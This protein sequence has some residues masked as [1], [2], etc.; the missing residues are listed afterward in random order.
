MPREATT[1]KVWT[2]GCNSLIHPTE[3]SPREYAWGEN[4]VNRGGIVQNRPG[5]KVRASIP[6]SKIQG[7]CIFTPRNSTARLVA[8]VDGNIYQA[9][10][11]DYNFTKIDGLS[12]SATAEFVVMVP[13]VKSVK[14]NPDGS[15]T[16]I[17]PTPVLMIQ[18]G[19]NRCGYWDGSTTKHLNPE[20][21]D[22][23]TPIGLWMAWTSSRLWVMNGR[24][25]YASDIADPLTF[26]EN[27]YL[28]ER[29]NFD[30]PDEGMGL[31]ETADQTGLLAFTSKTTTAFKSYI[32]DR[33]QWGQTPDFQ[34]I[35]VPGVGC[36]AP[37]TAR[38]QYGETYFLSERGFISLNAALYTQRNNRLETQDG[39]MMRSKRNLSARVTAACSG[40]FENYFLVSVPSGSKYNAH[41]WA[42][43]QSPIDNAPPA[44][45]GIWTGVRPVEW[46]TGRV[47]GRER[48]FFASYDATAVDDTHIHI[49]EGFQ[50]SREDEGGAMVAQFET[51][52]ITSDAKQAFKY[53]EIEATEI[54]GDVHLKVYVGATRGP[55]YLLGETDLT[56]EKGSIGGPYQQSIDLDT[57]LEAYKPQSRLV[58]TNE[59]TPPEGEQNC[60]PEF[61]G[62]AATADKGFAILCE[63][64]GRMGIREIRMVFGDT[65]QNM[66]GACAG[67]EANEVNAVTDTGEEA[68]P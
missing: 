5:F 23:G 42:L 61:S 19:E 9:S 31:I 20:A 48:C 14:R 24:R 16:V 29:S 8:A 28:A 68:Q 62:E 51:G 38:N 4:I 63:W 52:I 15:L 7:L 37:R 43:D 39:A 21:P 49:W 54:L 53:A 36:V 58:K 1:L 34:K 66:Q 13:A 27:T 65:P 60:P 44:W 25:V 67:S 2:G 30:L 35:I 64:R 45:N 12:F 47:G 50:G 11:P 46:A 33:T 40:S 3:I 26:S 17:T 22:L 6:G 57:I 18:D 32:F 55:W 41:T 56:A 10:Y 59:L